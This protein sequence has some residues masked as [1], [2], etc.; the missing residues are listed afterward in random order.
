MG[1]TFAGRVAA[2]LLTAVEL[3]ELIARTGEEYERR[4][5]DLAMHPGKLADLRQKLER[6][7]LTTLLF[8][9]E[10]FT[11]NLES[12]YMTMHARRRAGLP[13]EHIEVSV[14]R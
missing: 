5:V 11:R 6:N 13:P 1:E 8:D 2:S 9:T 3:P 14:R 7:R 12:A 4:A 10:T